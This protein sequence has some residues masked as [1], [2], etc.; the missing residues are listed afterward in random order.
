MACFESYYESTLFPTSPDRWSEE[1][2]PPRTRCWYCGSA[3]SPMNPL[4]DDHVYAESRGGSRHHSN[5]RRACG[6]CNLLAKRDKLLSDFIDDRIS[7]CFDEIRSAV[8]RWS[9]LDSV[10]RSRYEKLAA[11]IG[12]AAFACGPSRPEYRFDITPATTASMAGLFWMGRF[13]FPD[14]GSMAKR[15]AKA[16][17]LDVLTS[18]MPV[19]G[20]FE[21]REVITYL[22]SEICHHSLNGPMVFSEQDDCGETLFDRTFRLA[23]DRIQRKKDE[24]AQYE[25]T[26][27]SQ[28]MPSCYTPDGLYRKRRELELLV[29]QLNRYWPPIGSPEMEEC[30]LT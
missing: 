1:W 14:K 2:V 7:K 27:V 26:I 29:S 6:G 21:D 9:K 20:L 24:V 25:Q 23:S 18:V 10:W 30:L 5:M 11:A 3:E 28:E 8:A 15:I 12:D 19:P 22:L 16:C 17:G 4:S 13:E